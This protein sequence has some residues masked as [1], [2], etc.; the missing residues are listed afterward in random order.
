MANI[1]SLNVLRMDKAR[2]NKR[3]ERYSA[4][5]PIVILIIAKIKQTMLII[6]S[7]VLNEPSIVIIKTV[8]LIPT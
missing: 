6:Y 7:T 2:P 8:N 3:N 5:N 4:L 1:I